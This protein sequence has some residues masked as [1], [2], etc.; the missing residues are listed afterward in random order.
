MHR[1]EAI[2]CLQE[3]LRIVEEICADLL[4][5]VFLTLLQL[6][7]VLL[8][9]LLSVVLQQVFRIL[10]RVE[11]GFTEFP[12]ERV[13]RLYSIHHIEDTHLLDAFTLISLI[14]HASIFDY[15]F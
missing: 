3:A 11:V 1:A 10:F 5:Q 9:I 4:L 13:F 6:V 7:N 2:T 14:C 15:I 12:D 8:Q